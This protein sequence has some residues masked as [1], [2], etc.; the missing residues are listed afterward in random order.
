MLINSLFI[1][2]THLGNPN[3]Q[4]DKLLEVFKMYQFNNL[5]IVG[6][7]IDLTYLK[8]K[9]FWR[10]EY[11]KVIQKV[12]KLSKKDINIVYLIGNHDFYIRALIEDGSIKLGDNILICDEYIHT[13][14]K[15]EKILMF[16]GDKMDG[17]IKTHP[18]IYWLG[19]N[20]YEFSIMINKIYNRFRKLFGL[21]YWSLSAYL[22]TRVKNVVK[23][24]MEYR[25]TALVML[26]DN[27]CDSILIGHT[28]HPEIT[29]VGTK[30]FY[31]TGDFLESCSYIIEDI[32][33]DM[34]LIY[35]KEKD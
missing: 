6:D 9:F 4:A 5:Y 29:T 31:N 34:E 22:K 1:S 35:W 27:K 7:F 32:N 14:I 11:S 21:N 13:T 18:F 19:D 26:E 24:L 15:G 23:F 2:D 8:R 17:F 28:H 25:K 33:G 3:C 30:T 12:L 10:N 20:A 16:H